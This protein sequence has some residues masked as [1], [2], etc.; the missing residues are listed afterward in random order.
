[1][2]DAALFLPEKAVE[3]TNQTKGKESGRWY[4]AALFAT[5]SI[6]RLTLLLPLSLFSI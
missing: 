2:I 4:R 5:G 6:E 1:M 3:A